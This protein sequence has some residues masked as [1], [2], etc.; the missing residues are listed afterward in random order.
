MR[1]IVYI[2]L[3][4]VGISLGAVGAAVPVLPAFPF[5]LLSAFCF[6][7]CS[8][9]LCNW[10]VN[11]RLYRENLESFVK[12]KGMT[13]KAKCR[14]LLTITASLLIGFVFSHNIPIVQIILICVWV[15]H[16]LFI[17]FKIKTLPN[18]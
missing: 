13:P 17:T 16:I 9:K 6:S 5:L 7:R 8:P 14:V 2:G 3:G 12:G 1:K 11:T 4:C 10:F 15:F 18:E